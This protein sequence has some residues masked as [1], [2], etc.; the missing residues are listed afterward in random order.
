MSVSGRG[1]SYRERSEDAPTGDAP[2]E[3]TFWNSQHYSNLEVS[4]IRMRLACLSGAELE[5]QAMWADSLLWLL[6]DNGDA[7]RF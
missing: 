7:R 1:H 5:L 6:S 2:L 4:F 3:A